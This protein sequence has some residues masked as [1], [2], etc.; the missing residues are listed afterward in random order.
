MTEPRIERIGDAILYEGDCY[1]I[2]PNLPKVDA[3]ITDPPYGVEK[4]AWDGSFPPA[5]A[6][7]LIADALLDGGSAIVFPGEQ[8]APRKLALMAGSGLDYQW[9]LVWY[10]SNAMQFGKTGF[11]KKSLA[12]WFS[13]GKPK[14]RPKMLDIFEI[15]IV[16]EENNFG[17]PSPKPLK[18]MAPLVDGFS[19]SG[20]VVLDPFLGSGTTGV[21]CAN[22]GRKFIGIER[23]PKYFDI[24]CERIRAAYS[25]QR[26]F[27]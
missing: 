12:W 21:A 1:T 3:V 20:D 8:E 22:L 16:A 5:E 15:P 9:V 13:K 18:V 17:H 25:Q 4:A 2:L 23:E 24:A 27:A 14:V 19:R 10:A 26:L 7:G 6:W 11:T